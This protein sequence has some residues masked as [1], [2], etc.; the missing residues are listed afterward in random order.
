[1][2]FQQRLNDADGSYSFQFEGEELRAHYNKAA[3]L[4]RLGVEKESHDVTREVFE[5][6]KEFEQLREEFGL[7]NVEGLGEE[8]GPDPEE[9]LDEDEY[10]E[11]Q[12]RLVQIRPAVD[13]E[14]MK[15]RM[16]LIAEQIVEFDGVSYG[17]TEEWTAIP[18][19]TQ[20]EILKQFPLE[21]IWDLY[22]AICTGLEEDEGNS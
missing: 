16:R 2:D 6:D 12:E 15:P 17:D 3:P 4:E 1:M 14:A 19:N 18:R 7:E 20:L 5:Q 10:D 8:D 21:E 9:I 22:G 11:Y 13:F